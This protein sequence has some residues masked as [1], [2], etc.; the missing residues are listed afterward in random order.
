MGWVITLVQVGLAIWK[1]TNGFKSYAGAALIAAGSVGYYATCPRIVNADGFAL[2]AWMTPDLW[3]MLLGLGGS[4]AVAGLRSAIESFRRQLTPEAFQ[5]LV[6]IVRKAFEPY[7]TPVK[8]EPVP[9]V[10][11]QESG[12]SSD[13]ARASV[14]A[15]A[16]CDK[17]AA[18]IGQLR[19]SRSTEDDS[20]I[21]DLPKVVGSLLVLLALAGAAAAEPPKAVIQGAE[22]SAAG[23]ICV[24]DATGSENEPTHF[25]WDIQPEVRGRRQLLEIEGQKRVVIATFPGRYLLTLTV[26]NPDGHSMAHREIVIPGSAPQPAPGP[27]PA[28]PVPGPTPA[29]PSPAPTP[30]PGP[31]APEPSPPQPAPGPPESRFNLVRDIA[32]WSKG[33]AKAERESYALIC[34]AMAAE[35]VATPANFS[36]ANINEMAR[37]I[38]AAFLT[39]VGTPRLGLVPVVLKLNARL[40]ELSPQLKTLDDWAGLFR[41]VAAGLR[42][43]AA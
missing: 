42:W 7:Q 9:D 12:P 15:S 35:I 24:F 19:Q 3:V 39:K 41:E 6:D 17:T 28:P 21:V 30:T 25:S 23:E 40:R 37:K 2:P 31:P 10:F 22:P 14:A 29:P 27:Q 18:T 5:L 8:P 32:M 26:S 11:P 1:A 4:L 13:F 43:E 33:I 20:G 36:G 34:D 16:F 38:A